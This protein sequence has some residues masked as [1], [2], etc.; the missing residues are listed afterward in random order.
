[1][2]LK[3][4]R[5]AHCGNIVYKVVDKGRPC[6]LLRREDGGAGPQHH[7]RG[8]GE[9]RP[10]GGG[11]LPTARAIP[12]PSRWAPWNTPCFPSIPFSLSPLRAA[13]PWY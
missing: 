5:C 10:R 7:R 3:L 13:T 11:R 1:M 12:C 4:Y 9:A 6:L 2:E 8:A